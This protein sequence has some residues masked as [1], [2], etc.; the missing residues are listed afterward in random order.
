LPQKHSILCL[1]KKDKCSITEREQKIEM[2]TADKS[3]A[4]KYLFLL[5]PG[6]LCQE[7]PCKNF[8]TALRELRD[9]KCFKVLKKTLIP[10]KKAFL[11]INK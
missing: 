11:Q 3:L 7:Q 5:E 4:N 6:R 2:Q 8:N 1:T 10:N 9:K